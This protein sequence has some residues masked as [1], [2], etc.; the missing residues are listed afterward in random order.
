MTEL[1]EKLEKVIQQA[2]LDGALTE[3]AVA[4]F[5]SL[6]KERNALKDANVEWEETDKKSKLE[7]EQLSRDIAKMTGKLGD[8]Q[9]RERELVERETKVT[10]LEIEKECSDKRVEDHVKMVELIF[11]NLEVRRNV[12]P[13][14]PSTHISESGIHGMGGMIEEKSQVEKTE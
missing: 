10:R 9:T 14:S 4:Q 8:Y 12:F 11:R 1:T 5:H 6:V 3:D 7:C 13:V 2:A